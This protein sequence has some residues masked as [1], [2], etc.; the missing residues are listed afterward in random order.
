VTVELTPSCLRLRAEL[1]SLDGGGGPWT[2]RDLWTR[3]EESTSCGRSSSRREGEDAGAAGV[4]HKL[5]CK[6][7]GSYSKVLQTDR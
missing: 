6:W 3:L 5:P 1:E 2:R 4:R 7:T